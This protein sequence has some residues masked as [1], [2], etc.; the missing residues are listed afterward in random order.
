[1]FDK[2]NKNKGFTLVELLVSMAVFSITIVAC[3]QIFA[4]AIKAQGTILN[5]QDNL[6]ET[7]YA[8]ERMSRMIRM[9]KK[10]IDCTDRTDSTTCH[11]LVNK[12]Y[13]YNY[14]INVAGNQLTFIDYRN[15][16]HRFYLDSGQLKESVASDES[17][18]INAS[19]IHPLI[20]D[21]FTINVLK[22]N[23]T[24]EKQE[25]SFQPRVA[26]FLNIEKTGY[27][28]SNIKIQTTIS[29]RNI[30]ILY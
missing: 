24:G 14:E 5:S 11:C 21:E 12:G 29:Q 2:K 19:N 4:S 28:D 10:E 9:A 8:M 27:P 16:C 23:I 1:M 7:S 3:T 6:N 20:S 30:D 26:L 18:L 25:D 15:Q 17:G 22:F 13:G